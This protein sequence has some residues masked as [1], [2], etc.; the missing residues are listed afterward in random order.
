MT[1]PAGLDDEPAP[2]AGEHLVDE[3]AALLV[4]SSDGRIEYAN[5]VAERFYGRPA[6]ELVGG[7][8]SQLSPP[9]PRGLAGY[10]RANA[11]RREE[12]RARV[13]V[14]R[15][16]GSLLAVDVRLSPLRSPGRTMVAAVDASRAVASEQRLLEA[17]RA[18]LTLA[19][20]NQAMLRAATIEE[21]FAETCRIAVE[22]GGYLGAWVAQPGPD[23]SIRTA[24][25]AGDLGDYV[26]ELGLTTDPTH[27]RGNSPTA[28]ALRGGEAYFSADFLDDPVTAP[29]HEAARRQ[30]IRAAAT[31]PLH[32]G[33]RTVA[34][35]TLW[36]W[37]PDVFGERTRALLHNVAEN[38]SFA[39]EAFE[40]RDRL[41]QVA[42][43]RSLLLTRLVAAQE[44]ERARIAADVHD[45]SVQS[46]AAIDLRLGLLRRR[47]TDAAP[48]L[49]ADVAQLQ[50]MTSRVAVSL[51]DL[52]FDLEPVPPG[53]DLVELVRDAARHLLD[54]TGL[55]WSVDL[56]STDGQHDLRP[57]DEVVVQA[58]RITREALINARKHATGAQHLA[59]LIS[60]DASG[61]EVTV[62]DDGEGVDTAPAARPGH[63]GLVTMQD[64]A[65][66]VGGW[67]RFES[68]RQ[69]GT[70]VRFW[71]PHHHD[72]P[73]AP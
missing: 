30:G 2:D 41:V 31:V 7:A 55:A 44:D 25:L 70:T 16:D 58:L 20:I 10:V 22:I 51:R 60:V 47:L 33:G 23:Q 37:E 14:L 28:R 18:Y 3:P 54:H 53:A 15:E 66:L 56:R 57:A 59:I 17:S 52:L 5:Q 39:L 29:W 6:E 67:C 9:G 69:G 24:A 73:T 68:S 4:V 11:G 35:L 42:A 62:T 27:P 12:R 21:L 43:Q 19:E 45:D 40:A 65:E 72:D 26:A 63:R 32:R 71:M 8:L 49:E 38:V 46:L 13:Q 48:E 64:R 36:A 50:S 61:F 1:D 34:V